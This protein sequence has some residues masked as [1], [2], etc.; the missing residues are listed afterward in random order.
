MHSEKVNI[1]IFR[2]AM[3]Y[4]CE[5]LVVFGCSLLRSYLFLCLIFLVYHRAIYF[6]YYLFE[7]DRPMMSYGYLMFLVL[8]LHFHIILMQIPF[9]SPLARVRSSVPMPYL[10]SSELLA[11]GSCYFSYFIF[12]IIFSIWT[13]RILYCKLMFIIFC[14]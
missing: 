9:K 7:V 1:Y 3:L 2:V 5:L 8:I 4:Y 11:S 6:I 12:F 14:T 13:V 10:D